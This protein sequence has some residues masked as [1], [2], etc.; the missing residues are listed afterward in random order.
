VLAGASRP[1][2]DDVD[3]YLDASPF[4]GAATRATGTAQQS[5]VDNSEVR[6]LDNPTVG[7][8]KV[9]LVAGLDGAV[10][11]IGSLRAVRDRHL[12]RHDAQLDADVNR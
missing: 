5:S 10:H 9:K 3:M 7:A 2:S 4:T 1:W 11:S 6:I 12:R 8:W